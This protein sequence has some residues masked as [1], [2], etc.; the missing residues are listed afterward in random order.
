MMKVTLNYTVK[1]LT[2]QKIEWLDAQRKREKTVVW[3]EKTADVVLSS[4]Q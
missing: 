3:W 1:N 2:S 4:S